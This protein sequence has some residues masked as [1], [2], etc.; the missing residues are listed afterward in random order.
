MVKHVRRVMFVSLLLASTFISM[1]VLNY[2][3]DVREYFN[4][5]MTLATVTVFIILFSI[6]SFF[7]WDSS[8]LERKR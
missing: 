7:S 1:I 3:S 4:I 5:I 2:V 6:I 8:N